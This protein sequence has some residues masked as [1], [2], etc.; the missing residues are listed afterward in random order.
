MD[1]REKVNQPGDEAG[2]EIAYDAQG[3]PY[4]RQ[5]GIDRDLVEE[6]KYNPALKKGGSSQAENEETGIAG[7]IAKKKREAAEAA[8]KAAS[9]AKET[10]ADQ[11]SALRGATPT[12][13][14]T[15]RPKKAEDGY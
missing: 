15:P 2:M 7:Q 3:R 5:K 1:K 6:E 13:R 11:A 8:R 14:P 4:T 9:P 10:S 12:P